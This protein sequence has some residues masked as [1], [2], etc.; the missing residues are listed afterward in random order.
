[1]SYL[2]ECMTTD[3]QQF[4]STV[5]VPISFLKFI[6]QQK[7]AVKNGVANVCALVFFILGPIL[8]GCVSAA[9]LVIGPQLY[10]LA[11][12]GKMF[13]AVVRLVFKDD[14]FQ[15][16]FEE[17]RRTEIDEAML[18]IFFFNYK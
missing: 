16:Y 15:S 2:T 3:S 14:S 8:C 17:L 10:D 5:Y 11:T 4:C 1:M 12:W 18:V 7:R 6:L 13:A 9:V